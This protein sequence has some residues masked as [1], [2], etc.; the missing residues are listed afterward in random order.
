MK[1]RERKPIISH[2]PVIR[3]FFDDHGDRVSVNKEVVFEDGAT[4]RSGVYGWEHCTGPDE[5]EPYVLAT[6]IWRFWKQ[7]AADAEEE[8]IEA[9]EFLESRASVYGDAEEDI[10]EL[11]RLKAIARRAQKEL[12]KAEEALEAVTPKREKRR[13]RLMAENAQQTDEFRRRLR[14]IKL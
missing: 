4:A 3:K 5:K 7:R 8:F 2:D 12:S 11:K 6:D 9:K 10:A 1:I 14:E 13:R